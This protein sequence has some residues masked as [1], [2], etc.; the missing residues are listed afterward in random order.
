MLVRLAQLQ[1]GGTVA[2]TAPPRPPRPI[3][4]AERD[5]F[6][7]LVEALIE[8]AR[9]R[10]RRRRRRY[11]AVAAL[12]AFVG[13]ALATIVE[14]AEP[15]QTAAPAS[16]LAADSSAASSQA[17]SQIAFVLSSSW[18]LGAT[19]CCAELRVINPGGS[20]QRTSSVRRHVQRPPVWSPDG[21]RIAFMTAPGFSEE[22]AR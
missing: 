7:A 18:A 4:P 9:Q 15:S 1:Q 2:V 8:E 21:R 17:R 5:E 10:A 11:G 13:L 14:G 20:G 19:D 22:I 12:V 3:D 6:D 16:A